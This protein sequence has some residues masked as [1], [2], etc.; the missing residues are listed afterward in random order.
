M[1]APVLS[2]KGLNLHNGINFG[3]DDGFREIKLVGPNGFKIRIPS[4]AKAGE[5]DQ[6]SID[7]SNQTS[8]GYMTDDGPYVVGDI[9]H[10]DPTN[11]DDYPLSALNRVLVTHALRQ[12]G[13]S[14]AHKIN[15]CSGLP[16]K[17]YYRGTAIN[18]KLIKSKQANLLRNDVSAL[19][20]STGTTDKSSIVTI[21]NHQVISEGIAAW[22]NVVMIP[23]GK[24]GYSIDQSLIN[25]DIAFIDI[26]GRT[27]EIV[28]VNNFNI[29]KEMSSTLYK[30]MLDI[31]S[32][33]CEHVED[34]MDATLTIP[35]LNSIMNS[36]KC[37]LFGQ[38]K[39]MTK[40]RQAA[41]KIVVEA[42]RS[43]VRQL[44]GNA[45]SLYRVYFVGGTVEAIHHLLD[46]WFQQQVIPRDP[47]FA[48]A[49]GMYKYMTA[50]SKP[51]SK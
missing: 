22:M 32:I 33:I 16:Y 19:N 47:G 30:G 15:I 45:S 34:S 42:I 17:K 27:T 37:E 4:Q 24:G 38:I 13:L 43:E 5:P 3:G 8:F 11:H 28:V 6:I 12:T 39:D 50:M 31:E 21:Q 46:G 26:G 10:A 41:Q 18:K 36:G 1:N 35:Q 14:H 7:E 23:D 2:L 44:L 20:S 48:N 51:S 9:N 25:K 40:H 49:N 29:R